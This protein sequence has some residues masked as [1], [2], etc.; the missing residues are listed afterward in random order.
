M[1]GVRG[2]IKETLEEYDHKIAL[3]HG[4]GGRHPSAPY[5]LAKQDDKDYKVGDVVTYY[6]KEPQKAWLHHYGKKAYKKPKLPNYEKAEFI[7]NYNFDYDMEY[8][9]DRLETHMKRF[10]TIFTPKEFED[11]FNIS[12]NTKDKKRLE[13]YGLII[14]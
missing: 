12:L 9:S 10:L 5:E 2:N 3:G 1:I 4:N 13:S 6:I 7:K 8:Y 11:A 14:N